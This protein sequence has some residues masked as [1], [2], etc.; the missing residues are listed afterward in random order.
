MNPE[1][2]EITTMNTEA[3]TS[4]TM[5]THSVLNPSAEAWD[6]K[7][8]RGEEK[9]RTIFITF[10]NGYPLSDYQ[11]RNFFNS[12]YGECVERIYIHR[13]DDPLMPPLFGKVI[14]LRRSIPLMLFG[15]QDEVHFTVDGMSLRCKKYKQRNH[16]D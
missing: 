11:I 10:S 16:R 9:D 4:D 7:I 2:M 8:V 5:S 12:K 3:V 6:P 15:D 13:R 14:F 1:N